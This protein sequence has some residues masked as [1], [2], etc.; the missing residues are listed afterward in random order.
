MK[1]F[2][3]YIQGESDFVTQLCELIAFSYVDGIK[4]PFNQECVNG[5]RGWNALGE[6]EIDFGFRGEFLIFG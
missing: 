3:W 2:I 6:I 5:D 1:A 4:Y